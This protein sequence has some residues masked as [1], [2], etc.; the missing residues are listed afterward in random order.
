MDGVPVG[1]VLFLK[2]TAGWRTA[3]S[4]FLFL[5]SLARLILLWKIRMEFRWLL[6]RG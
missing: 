4:A 6:D 2:S 5:A 3:F 1:Y